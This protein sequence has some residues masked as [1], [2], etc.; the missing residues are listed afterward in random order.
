M[1]AAAASFVKN[2]EVSGLVHSVFQRVINFS[3]PGNN[4][5]SISRSDV[6]NSPTNIITSL[7]IADRYDQHGIRPGLAVAVK[8]N[9]LQAGPFWINLQKATLWTPAI[10]GTMNGLPCGEIAAKL[11]RLTDWAGSLSPAGGLAYFLPRL[12]ALLAGDIDKLSCSDPFLKV[13]LAA[14][15]GL[16]HSWRQANVAGLRENI[17]KLIGLGP[18]LTPSGDDLLAGFMASLLAMH[19]ITGSGTPFLLAELCTMVNEIASTNTNDLSRE[20]LAFAAKGEVPEPMDAM[21]LALLTKQQTAW[22]QAAQQLLKVGASSGSDQLLGIA[23]GISLYL[24]KSSPGPG[25]TP[26]NQDG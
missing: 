11:S 5:I 10:C 22:E 16:C 23:L 20:L 6:S 9:I 13:A 19:K 14:L 24:E 1:G 21:I 4:L 17:S 3:F 26:E 18:G 15:T 8:D 12:S 25:L 7:R 2:A